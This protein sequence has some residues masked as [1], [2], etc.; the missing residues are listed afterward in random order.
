MCCHTPADN[1][2]NK[3]LQAKCDDL[4][5][6]GTVSGLIEMLKEIPEYREAVMQGVGPTLFEGAAQRRTGRI[7]VDMTG[8][9]SGPVESISR[10]A[11]SGVGTIVGMHM[12]EEH[13]KKAKAEHVNVVI[14]GHMSSDSLGMNLVLD[15]FERG[16]GRDHG[17]FRVHARQPRL[18]VSHGMVPRAGGGGRWRT[19]TKRYRV[20]SRRSARSS[21]PGR[22]RLCPRAS[23]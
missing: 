12:N 23:F 19:G 4:G 17:L 13:R 20:R 1:N 6:D 9:T 7:M 21:L 2:V 3:Y 16:R 10:L 18:S 14:A 11:A 22:W 8:G 15:E 5:S